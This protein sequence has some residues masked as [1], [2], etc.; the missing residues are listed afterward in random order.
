[1]SFLHML[2]VLLIVTLTGFVLGATVN[3]LSA[4]SGVETLP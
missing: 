2:V 1:M 4:D 3:E